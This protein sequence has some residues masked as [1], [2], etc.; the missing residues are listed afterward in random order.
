MNLFLKYLFDRFFAFWGLILLLPIFLCIII[1]IK[2]KMPGPIIFRQLRVGQYGKLFTIYKFRSMVV[3]DGGNSISVKGDNRITKIGAFLR[4]YKLDE[5]PELLN[6]LLGDMSFVGPRPDVPGYVDSLK[7]ENRRILELKPGITGP[8][9]LKFANEEEILSKVEDPIKYNDEIIFPE[10]VNI[11]LN[12]L[13]NQ[14]IWLDLKI[15]FATV[16]RTNY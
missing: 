14:S 7:G 11:N 3:N 9:T 5:L 12:Y 10:K 16:F 15:I 6:I 13:K 2:L 4:K 1:L 8:A